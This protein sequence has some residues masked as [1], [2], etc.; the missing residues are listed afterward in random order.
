[1]RHGLAFAYALPALPLAA[2]YLP[3]FVHLPTFYADTR[4]LGL[5]AVGA[6]LLVARLWDVATDPMIGILS[7][8]TPSRLGRRKL[9][10]GIGVP[11][12]ILSTWQ[13]F[14][15]DD[16]A[17]LGH[18]L[19]WSLA[20]S[21]A[22]TMIMLPYQA[23]GAELSGDYHGRTTIAAWR[24]AAA[25][26]GT[27]TAV[28]LPVALGVGASA[29][30]SLAAIAVMVA[31]L[32]PIT[33]AIALWRVPEAPRPAFA[34]L[35][36]RKAVELV[37]RNRPFTRLIAAYLM[38]GFANG[39]PATLFILFVTHCLAAPDMT[40]PL[41]ALY[42][43]CGLAGVPLWLALSRRLGKHRTWSLAMAGACVAFL[44]VP[45]LDPGD[46]GLFFAICVVTGLSVGA[47]LSLPHAIQADVVDVDTAA[48]GGQR[49]GIYF[50]F[51]GMATKLALA[52]AVGIA[53]PLLGAAGFL[54]GG[55]N[56]TPAALFALAALYGWAPIVFKVGAIALVWR[57]P[58]DE[59]RQRTLRRSIEAAARVAP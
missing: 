16:D 36:R 21:L 53:F 22:W 35:E 41:L 25:V 24:E 38:N 9:W 14:R 6:A 4:G 45:F 13:L 11:L 7:D 31:I 44:A 46:I 43:A 26:A 2:L 3:T 29:G 49:T 52:G 59:V 57:F 30:G 18:L 39:I 56:Q 32:L 19:V 47:D 55:G 20:L 1:M 58:L 8:R 15:P 42:F 5:E 50:A 23:W 51:W 34:P 54:V 40:G 12:A 27:L 33:V 37:V 10:V 17:G 48:G 28:A